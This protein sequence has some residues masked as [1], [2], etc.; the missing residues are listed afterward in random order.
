MSHTDA[1]EYEH[2]AELEALLA[3]RGY[4]Y[5][6]LTNLRTWRLFLV[7]YEERDPAESTESWWQTVGYYSL[8]M[9]LLIASDETDEAY[10]YPSQR[11]P[12]LKQRADALY[13]MSVIEIS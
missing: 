12:A 2:P 13:R 11:T 5:D 7:T 4:N 6:F 1:D 9:L 3:A 8:R 10:S